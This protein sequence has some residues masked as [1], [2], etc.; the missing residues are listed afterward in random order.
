MIKKIPHKTFKQIFSQVPR[1]CV[2]IAIK[3]KQGVVLIKREIQP[4]LGQWHTPGGTVYFGE[5]LEQAGKRIAKEETGQKIE[6]LKVLGVLE[7]RQEIKLAGRHSVTVF[8]LAKPIGGKLRGGKQGKRIG[9]FKKFPQ[10]PLLA[11]QKFLRQHK[12]VK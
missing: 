6:I 12:L 2:D 7:M 1:L 10:P 9:F 5:S 4:F 11:H 3:N 8:L